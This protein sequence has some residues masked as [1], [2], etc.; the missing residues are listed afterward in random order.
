MVI[1]FHTYSDNKELS[2]FTR[3]YTS[4]TIT[5]FVI[6]YL[7]QTQWFVYLNALLFVVCANWS[8]AIAEYLST[9]KDPLEILV[10][11]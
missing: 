6:L 4:S 2:L 5:V 7:I 11:T 10:A 8:G 9:F 1:Y 3:I